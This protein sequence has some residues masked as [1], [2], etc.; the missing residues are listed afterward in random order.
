MPEQ[1]CTHPPT[2]QFA[3]FARDIHGDILCVGCCE[4]GEVLKGGATLDDESEQENEQCL[5]KT[6]SPN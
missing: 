6:S 5:Q 2:R 1:P 3:W 4:C